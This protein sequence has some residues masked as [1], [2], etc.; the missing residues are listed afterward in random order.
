MSKEEKT[1][2]FIVELDEDLASAFEEY[3]K[4]NDRN[5]SQQITHMI[6]EVV[7]KKKAERA[8]IKIMSDMFGEKPKNPNLQE[9]AE[10][11][12]NGGKATDGCDCPRCEAIRAEIKRA[13]AE[14][15]KASEAEKITGQ[16]PD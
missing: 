5:A 7:L 13:E 9:V 6:K 12:A 4:G 8:V 2:P 11:V 1:V 16:N 15:A 14:K 3:A 10:F